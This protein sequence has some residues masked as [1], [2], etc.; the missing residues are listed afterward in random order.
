MKNRKG[1][2]LIELLAV[3]VILAIIALIAIP[4]VKRVI[5]ENGDITLAISNDTYCITKGYSDRNIRVEEE[6]TKCELPYPT[7]IDL[8]VTSEDLGINE[9]HSCVKGSI[10][11]APG[12]AFAIKVNNA[13]TYKF[14][15][16]ADDGNEATL[17][18]SNNLGVNVPWISAEDYKNKVVSGTSCDRNACT[19]KGPVTAV[20]KLKEREYTYT[21]AERK[22]NYKEFSETMRARLITYAEAANLGCEYKIEGS[23]PEWFIGTQFWTSTGFV[24]TDA[25]GVY[26]QGRS[27]TT[28]Q[29][30]GSL[31]L[32]PV[33][34]LDK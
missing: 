20:A 7:L 24:R 15:V 19:N 34:T 29:P 25:Y 26:T 23:C 32:R 14:Y 6:Y 28:Y 3:I 17:I 33:I 5:D 21:D 2:T 30:A 31:G 8:A 10:K 4:T 12:T 1:F 22:D 9:V 16:V 27:L 13:Q 18:L 11:C